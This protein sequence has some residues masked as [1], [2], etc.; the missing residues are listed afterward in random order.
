M[1]GSSVVFIR[2]NIVPPP[3]ATP[4]EEY[5]PDIPEHEPEDV[6]ET[7]DNGDDNGGND[8]NGDN[9]GDSGDSTPGDETPPTTTPPEEPPEEPP[10]IT[11]Q[12][13][14]FL[15]MFPGYSTTARMEYSMQQF[16]ALE[17]PQD[18]E[19]VVITYINIFGASKAG[20]LNLC[21]LADP[22]GIKIFLSGSVEPQYYGY[23]F[24]EQSEWFEYLW[25]QG[26]DNI[27]GYQIDEP[28]VK[29]AFPETWETI[30]PADRTDYLIENRLL[31]EVA[32]CKSH[33]LLVSIAAWYYQPLADQQER[34][35]EHE[36]FLDQLDIDYYCSS[37]YNVAP[38]TEYLEYFVDI[39]HARGI[40]FGV[41]YA[42]RNSW[43]NEQYITNSIN[44]L[45]SLQGDFVQFIWD[46]WYADEDEDEWDPPEGTPTCIFDKYPIEEWV[47]KIYA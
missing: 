41:V 20:V 37:D 44:E 35:C 15:W 46:E 5:V 1:A 2:A 31:E 38:N 14:V 25:G 36:K 7:P 17:V 23:N 19:K 29:Q 22:Y 4:D 43:G 16:A 24:S 27:I 39:C 21:N 28:N 8:D 9:N 45:K 42:T 33:N 34:G 47:T 10:E 11:A 26:V 40:P 32:W 13:Y 6:T 18:T 30:E 3:G 12:K